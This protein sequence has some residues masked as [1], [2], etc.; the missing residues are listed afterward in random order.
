MPNTIDLHISASHHLILYDPQFKAQKLKAQKRAEKKAAKRVGQLPAVAVEGDATQE[1]EE[2][3]NEAET[4]GD[5]S[6]DMGEVNEAQVCL[7]SALIIFLYY[8]L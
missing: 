8:G 3:E 4:A 7:F 5:G 2:T 6:G 1:P